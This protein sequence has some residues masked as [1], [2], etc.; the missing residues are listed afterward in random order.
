MYF[1]NVS[2]S[3]ISFQFFKWNKGKSTWWINNAQNFSFNEIWK[4]WQMSAKR[5][6][7]K[8]IHST[9]FLPSR[10]IAILAHIDL[11]WYASFIISCLL[12]LLVFVQWTVDSNYPGNSKNNT[13]NLLLLSLLKTCNSPHQYFSACL[14]GQLVQKKWWI[15]ECPILMLMFWSLKELFKKL[16]LEL[17]KLLSGHG[18]STE[19][20]QHSSLETKMH[21]LPYWNTV[22]QQVLKLLQH[23]PPLHL[24]HCLPFRRSKKLKG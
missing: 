24:F 20:H 17:N 4:R 3:T 19:V 14:Q 8:H 13:E 2:N 16:L 12:L 6:F 9:S 18:L 15:L 1:C 5:T 23:N 7:S 22:M 11:I 10:V 21:P